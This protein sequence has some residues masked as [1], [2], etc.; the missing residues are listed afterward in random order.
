MYGFL[1]RM[2]PGP[3]PI[4]VLLALLVFILVVAALFLWVF[5]WLSPRLPF[6][7]VTVDTAWGVGRESSI[8]GA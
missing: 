6:S 1:W 5:P 4:K 2:L 8:M 3:T 7:D